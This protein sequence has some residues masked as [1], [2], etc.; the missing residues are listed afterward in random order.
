MAERT[1]AINALSKTYSVTGWRVGWVIASAELTERHPQG[2]RLPDRRRGGAAPGGRRRRAGLPDDYYAR[3]GRRIPR[4]ARRPGA[5]ARGGRLPDVVP[6]RRLLRDDRHQR[7]DR[8]RRRHLL[9]AAR[10]IDPASR[11]CRAA[12]STRAPELGRTKVRFAFPKTRATLDAAAERLRRLAG[13][14]KRRT[15]PCRLSGRKS[16][17]SS[18][19]GPRY[20]AYSAR[21][22]E[23]HR[24]ELKRP[25]GQ[26]SCRS[27]RSGAAGIAAPA[28]NRSIRRGPIDRSNRKRRATNG[29]WPAATAHRHRVRARCSGRGEAGRCD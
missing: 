11:P 4:A 25:P 3:P 19:I 14:H 15:K 1:V 27:P 7:V 13:P 8:R 16:T 9:P 12:P 5:G 20:P 2:P 22:Q 21:R 17:N 26:T 6:G 28:A 18:S 23:R 24:G 29:P 10:R